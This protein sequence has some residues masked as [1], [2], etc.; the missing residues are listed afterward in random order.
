[1]RYEGL[2]PALMRRLK[3]T[4]SEMMRRK[5]SEYLS[6]KNCSSCGGTRLRPEAL[7]VRLDEKNI[8][9]VAA[10]PTRSESPAF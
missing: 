10:M 7:A 6:E 8:A 1:M 4:K 9:D 5:Y 3:E 2:L